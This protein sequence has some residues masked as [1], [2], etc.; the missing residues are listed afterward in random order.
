MTW[1]GLL[2]MRQDDRHR[3]L[4]QLRLRSDELIHAEV[5]GQPS[6]NFSAAPRNVPQ[7]VRERR[8]TLFPIRSDDP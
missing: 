3:R 4:Q 2:A 8:K 1:A 5:G 6:H 7:V